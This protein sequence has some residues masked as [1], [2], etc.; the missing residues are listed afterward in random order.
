MSLSDYINQEDVELVNKIVTNIN[1]QDYKTALKL[2]NTR[3]ESGVSLDSKEGPYLLSQLAGCLID[4]SSE[5]YIKEAA[6]KGIRIFEKNFDELQNYIQTSSLEYNLGNGAKF[7]ILRNQSE[8]EFKLE[9][10]GLLTET[11]N[12]YWKAYKEHEG[13]ESKFNAELLV[14]LGNT[15]S[16]SG[17]I[18]EA[19]QYYDQVIKSLPKF[20]QANA[21]RADALL[22][23]ARLSGSYSMNLILQAKLGFQKALESRELPS[24]MLKQ[25]EKRRDFVNRIIDESDFN[26]N[27]EIHDWEQTKEEYESLSVYRKFCLDNFLTLSEHSLYCKCLGARR[28]DIS[29]PI[30]TKTIGGDFVPSMEHVLNRL[31]IEFSLARLLYFQSVCKE[32]DKWETYD[33]EVVLTELYEGEEIDI[34]TEMLRAS[35]RYSFGILD[36]IGR[37]ICNLFNLAKP[38]DNIYFHRFWK[39][40]NARWNK[41]NSISTKNFALIALY[42]QATD[43]DFQ[44]GEW[45]IYKDWRNS[46]EHEHFFIMRSDIES[47]DL[48]NA[49]KSNPHALSVIYDEFQDKTL[50]MLQFARSAIFYFVWCVRIEG[51]KANNDKVEGPVLPITFTHK[52]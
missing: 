34:R 15:L 3:I 7:D 37:A 48:L 36:K 16:K 17:R 51:F 27:E 40:N 32:A 23:L 5:G 21:N 41:L 9:T 49:L 33:N 52:Y 14:N 42:S 4:I 6:N 8:F 28:D 26:S 38:S 47:P 11:K 12:H 43:L 10:V 50:H 13:S 25:F 2:I 24:W 39:G 29:I 45:S 44:K 35:F 22:W 20:P 30:P 31:K 1:D 46:L 18:V 19:L